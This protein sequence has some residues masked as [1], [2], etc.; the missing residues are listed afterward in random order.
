MNDQSQF[1]EIDYFQLCGTKLKKRNN[2]KVKYQIK[3]YFEK[4]KIFK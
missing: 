4:I 1:T 2:A 3:S